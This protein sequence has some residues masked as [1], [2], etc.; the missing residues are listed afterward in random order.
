M[1]RRLIANTARREL[2]RAGR[3]PS[4]RRNSYPRFALRSIVGTK[5]FGAIFRA[6]RR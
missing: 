3:P 1:F 2:M 4:R 6:L 5:L